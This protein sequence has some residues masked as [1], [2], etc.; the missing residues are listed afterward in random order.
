MPRGRPTSAFGSS[1]AASTSTGPR[2]RTG[3]QLTY[4]RVNDIRVK[5][6]FD[7]L[8][9]NTSESVRGDRE[10]STCEMLDVIRDADTERSRGAR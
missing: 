7:E 1:T 6:V 8:E 5:N 9:R 10:M 4:F 3:F 2:T